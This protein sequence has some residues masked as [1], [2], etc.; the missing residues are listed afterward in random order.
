M[1]E[2]SIRQLF[3]ETLEPKKGD[4]S[5]TLQ[6]LEPIR[7]EDQYGGYR[8]HIL[9]RLE[10]IR[11]VVPLDIATGDVITPHPVAYN[12]VS[13][14]NGE[15]IPIKAYSLETIIAEKLQ[16]IYERAFLNSRS[17]DFYDLY[18]LYHVQ[19]QNLNAKMM[20][21]ACIRTFSNRKTE[22]N[23]KKLRSLL[24]QIK[25]D[26]SFSTRWSA[27]V[28]RNRY[29]SGLSFAEIIEGAVKLLDLME[30]HEDDSAEE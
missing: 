17:K 13:I 25:D 20:R 3:I 24:M 23:R 8:V 19:Q 6:R 22:F 1:S 18:I 9:C 16:T 7:E 5:Y 28:K 14:F 21:E 15:Q 11:Q 27:Y 2:E 26:P 30:E 10:N 4:I 29:A 12:Y